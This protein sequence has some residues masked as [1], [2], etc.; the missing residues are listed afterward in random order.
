MY[1]RAW[2]RYIGIDGTRRTKVIDKV[3]RARSWL[4]FLII[5]TSGS[6][7]QVVMESDLCYRE[8]WSLICVTGSHG[9][10]LILW[11]VTGSWQFA[12]GI[13]SVPSWAGSSG[14]WGSRW[15]HRNSST[16]DPTAG[17][18]ENTLTLT[19]NMENKLAG[20]DKAQ[21]DIYPGITSIFKISTSNI[22]GYSCCSTFAR[23]FSCWTENRELALCSAI[24]FS[25]PMNLF[26]CWGRVWTKNSKT[27]HM[28]DNRIATS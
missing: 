13:F 8:S 5:D 20:H 4:V 1:R 19:L 25:S 2:S 23:S 3:N 17:D 18:R 14:C 16:G 12:V 27:L 10:W 28:L 21:F 26:A 9:I 11:L 6:V 15:S 7:L 22:P 24:L